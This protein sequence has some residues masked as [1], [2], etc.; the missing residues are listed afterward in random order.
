MTDSC[1][2]QKLHW[3]LWGYA[4]FLVKP[5]LVSS[6]THFLL[7]FFFLSFIWKKKTWWRRHVGMKLQLWARKGLNDNHRWYLKTLR[8]LNT[9]TNLLQASLHFAHDRVLWGLGNTD[10]KR[11]TEPTFG[12]NWNTLL[13]LICLRWPCVWQLSFS[14]TAWKSATEGS[15]TASSGRFYC[16]FVARKI[17]IIL[18]WRINF[19]SDVSAKLFNSCHTVQV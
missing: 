18:H 15:Y 9:K 7:L 3:L 19:V 6:L 8:V 12:L 14:H 13:N 16:S 5:W 4:T 2:N 10:R 1:L 11:E 17:S